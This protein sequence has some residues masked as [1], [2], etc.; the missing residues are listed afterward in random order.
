MGSRG[1]GAIRAMEL[2]TTCRASS[3]HTRRSKRNRRKRRGPA[4]GPSPRLFQSSSSAFETANQ[5][6]VPRGEAPT[7]TSGLLHGCGRST[8]ALMVELPPGTVAGN[9]AVI[10]LT[11]PPGVGQLTTAAKVPMGFN[12][13][14]ASTRLVTVTERTAAEERAFERVEEGERPVQG[15]AGRWTDQRDQRRSEVDRRAER[16]A[17]RDALDDLLLR[18][19]AQ[20][21]P[22]RC[23]VAP[24]HIEEDGGQRQGD[25]VSE[26]R[27]PRSV[28]LDVR[29]EEPCRKRDERD[30]REEQHAKRQKRPVDAADLVH[31]RVVVDPD[32]PDG[33]E[34]DRVSGV[35]RPD[36]QELLA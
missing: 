28:R 15:G 36:R 20:Q 31:H 32:D 18:V 8:V 3:T 30:D 1:C 27:R 5:T 4:L 11:T 2:S 14:G 9:P 33:E 13:V 34:A 6:K 22:P 10:L 25:S 19:G 29:R 26:R 7:N 23:G 12:P 21:P 35:L 16:V 17:A 24:D